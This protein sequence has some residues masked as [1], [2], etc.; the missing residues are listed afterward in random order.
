MSEQLYNTAILRLAASIPHTGRLDSPAGSATRVSPVCGSRVIVDVT[1]D[2]DGRIAA[3]GQDVRACA[4]G[5]ASAS[6]FGQHAVGLSRSELS[7]A[8]ETLAALLKGQMDDAA[9]LGR[10]S[11][12]AIFLPAVP[13]R[14]RHGSILLPWQ[15][16]LAA[17][18]TAREQTAA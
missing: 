2:A 7:A 15:A 6:L 13:H 17:M 9:A 11:D 5:Q 4:L 1:L 16:G 3:L 14:S 10:W 8:A 18:D 12:L